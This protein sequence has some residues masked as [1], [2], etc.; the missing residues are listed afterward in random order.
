MPRAGFEPAATGDI[1]AKSL[2]PTPSFLACSLSGKFVVD[3]RGLLA[4]F[5]RYLAEGLR[6]SDVL[7]SGRILIRR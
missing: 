3:L 2:N 6:C 5:E 1:P 7:P 4:D